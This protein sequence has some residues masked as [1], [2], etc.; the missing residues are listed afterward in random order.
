MS[1]VTK[2][3][4]RTSFL[5]TRKPEKYYMT[6]VKPFPAPYKNMPRYPLRGWGRLSATDSASSHFFFPFFRKH[7]N[8]SYPPSPLRRWPRLHD[9]SYFF[10]A[11]TPVT[12]PYLLL[13]PRASIRAYIR[14]PAYVYIYIYMYIFF[15][16]SF[17]FSS[18]RQPIVFNR[19]AWR[20]ARKRRPAL[21]GRL[22]R[23]GRDGGR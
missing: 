16:D 7:G 9:E 6:L 23:G 22:V 4:P 15:F 8:S 2:P 19:D 13:H 17:P 18:F 21:A 5:S 10:R 20:C 14:A 3:L 11:F 1:G 12:R